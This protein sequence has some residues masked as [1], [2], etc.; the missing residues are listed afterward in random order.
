MSQD[1]YHPPPLPGPRAPLHGS[2]LRTRPGGRLQDRA[3][4]GVFAHLCF[5]YAAG[6]TDGSES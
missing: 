3:A 1:S 6:L 4:S 2:C 5:G